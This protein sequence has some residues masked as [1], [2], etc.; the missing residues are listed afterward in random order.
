M[1][2]TI[3]IILLVVYLASIAVVNFFGLEV[4][5]FDGI[6]YVEGIQ[7][8]SITVQNESPVTIESQQMLGDKPLFIFDFIPAD[9]ANPYTAEAESIVNNPNAVQINYEVLPHLANETSVKF[10]Y[11]KETNEGAVVFHELSRTFV[12][13]KPNRAITVTIRATDG[14]N[15]CA[16]IV[17]MGRVPKDSN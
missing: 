4:K 9:E 13:L 8:N 11:D 17:L 12:F 1:K 6:T 14:S 16:Q 15:V 2:K 5:V 10:E 3:V 7:C